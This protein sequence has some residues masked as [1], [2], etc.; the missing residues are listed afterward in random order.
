MAIFVHL[1]LRLLLENSTDEC[2]DLLRRGLDPFLAVLEYSEKLKLSLSASGTLLT[3]TPAGELKRLRRFVDRGQLQLLASPLWDPLRSELRNEQ[4]AASREAWSSHGFSVAAAVYMPR[5]VD[6]AS[7]ADCAPVMLLPSSAVSSPPGEILSYGTNGRALAGTLERADL[8]RRAGS[9]TPFALRRAAIP[10]KVPQASIIE[11]DALSLFPPNM[12]AIDRRNTLLDLMKDLR[13]EFA[14]STE[15]VGEQ[16]PAGTVALAE[17]L[18]PEPAIGTDNS[19][20]R[21]MAWHRREELR[22]LLDP[23][24]EKIT[25]MPNAAANTDRLARARR[26]FLMTEAAEIWLPGG[27]QQARIREAFGEAVIS[28]QVEAD[29]ITHPEVDPAH[30][31]IDHELSDFD[32]DG[33]EELIADSQLKRLYFKPSA[34][35][36]LVRFEYKPRKSDLVDALSADGHNLSFL[37]GVLELPTAAISEA[38]LR[39][40]GDRITPVPGEKAELLVTRHTR[41]LFGLRVLRTVPIRAVDGAPRS[42]VRIVKHY[43]VK[44]G[45]GAHLN[46]ATTGLQFEYWVEASDAPK[47]DQYIVSR[48]VF[49]L[50][51]GNPDGISMRP[52]SAF[53]GAAEKTYPLNKSQLLRAA[54]VEG[55]LYGT[56][57]IDGIDAFVMDL[58]SAKPLTAL[59]TYNLESGPEKVF[60][61]LAVLLILDARRVFEDDKANTIFLS[62]K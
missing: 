55:G 7:A 17:A 25:M 9:K 6:A 53:G 49:M 40:A 2:L 57:L 42:A 16:L 36:A 13:G 35:G 21:Q 54:D 46:N 62:I 34:G 61:G 51:S 12:S 48:L 29:T 44:A 56:R 31:W 22:A 18:V 59:Y 15:H 1:H 26:F 41:D 27:Y 38:G 24:P 19:R 50:P 32:H 23:L 14:A 8:E 3:R 43:T 60:S 37:E 20:S 39:A 28:S 5:G 30:G 4:L 33:E 10:P 52:L 58:R 11:L 45:I 47:P